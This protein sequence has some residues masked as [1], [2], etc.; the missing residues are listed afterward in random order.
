MPFPF[1]QSGFSFFL[2]GA[3]DKW[4]NGQNYPL[5]KMA[6]RWC[7]GRFQEP[8]TGFLP[9]K[10]CLSAKYQ[11]PLVQLS[12]RLPGGQHLRFCYAFSR[13]ELSW[14]TLFSILAEAF[15]CDQTAFEL[16]LL[17]L[18]RFSPQTPWRSYLQIKSTS[19]QKWNPAYGP[20]VKETSS[21]RPLLWKKNRGRKKNK[22]RNLKSTKSCFK[23]CHFASPVVKKKNFHW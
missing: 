2:L 10:N 21:N 5:R 11:E 4:E 19:E 3:E 6:R 8:K 22:L 7:D 9:W 17:Q 16:K 15:L 18:L 23:M 12:K 13:R 14:K 1:S 20:F